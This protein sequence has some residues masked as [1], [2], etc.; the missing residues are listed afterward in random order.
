MAIKKNGKGEEWDPVRRVGNPCS[1][2]LVESY[3]TFVSEEQNQVGVLGNQAAP[4]LEPTLI[5]LL[6]DMCSRAQVAASL[7]ERISMTRDILL[8]SSAFYSMRRGYDC[9][10]TSGSQILELTRASSSTLSLVRHFGP[11][12]R[13]W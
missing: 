4:M 8:F 10:F 7:A 13:R 3:L 12:A 1:S 6:S 5:D 9:S 11:L 2:S